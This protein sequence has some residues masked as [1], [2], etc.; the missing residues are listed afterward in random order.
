MNRQVKCLHG[1]SLEIQFA[2]NIA[3]DG[4]NSVVVLF[5]QWQNA[6]EI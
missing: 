4:S 5:I 1:E 3:Q 2:Y 6:S